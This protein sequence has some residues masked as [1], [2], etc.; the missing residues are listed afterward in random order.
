LREREREGRHLRR[1]GENGKQDEALF[2][3]NLFPC[4]GMWYV[5]C[6]R[7]CARACV[8]EREGGR[9]G[10]RE[11]RVKAEGMDNR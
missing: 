8:C 10:G 11:C 3:F 4:V 5:K 1:K 6:V 2:F 9:E 7:V